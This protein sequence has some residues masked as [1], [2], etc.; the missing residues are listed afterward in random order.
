M[1]KQ[2]NS[3]T[4]ALIRQRKSVHDTCRQFTKSPSKGN[5]T[6]V[7]TLLNTCGAD[8]YIE[9]GLHL[10]Y[11]DNVSIGDRS[12]ININCTIIDGP[13]CAQ[14]IIT[15]GKDC[16]IGP[17]VQLL[18][19]SHDIDPT[20][21]LAKHNFAD[22]IVIANNVWLGAGVIVLAGVTI[23]ENS[24]IGAGSVVTKNVEH[25]SFYAGNPAKKLRTL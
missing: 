22:D 4:P 24:V 9:A 10:D 6:R 12:Y 7:K 5:L 18:S 25:D 16:F 19:V 11:G 17:N 13:Q 14:A 1:K 15:I 3:I 20:K 8:V 23:G 2:F 21:R